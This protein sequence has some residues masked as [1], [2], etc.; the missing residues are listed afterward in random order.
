MTG[1]DAGLGAGPAFRPSLPGWG[2]PWPAPAPTRDQGPQLDGVLNS[3]AGCS[4]PR[5]PARSAAAHPATPAHPHADT[6]LSG[7]LAAATLVSGHGQRGHLHLAAC[8]RECCRAPPGRPARDPLPAPPRAGVAK[9]MRDKKTGELLAVKFIEVGCGRPLQSTREPASLHSLRCRIK[10]RVVLR[11]E[12]RA[13]LPPLCCR[14]VLNPECGP[15]CCCSAERRSGRAQALQ[16]DQHSACACAAGSAQ[17]EMR[18]WRGGR[19]QPSAGAGS[20][21]RLAR[22]L[23][24]RVQPAAG[25]L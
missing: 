2:R 9:L 21:W 10:G 22:A 11:S 6:T 25:G 1:E 3:G 19:A 15:L 23:A 14:L 7:T 13:V 12:A 4:W 18:C 8:L 20:V 17:P 24:A 16:L 5:P